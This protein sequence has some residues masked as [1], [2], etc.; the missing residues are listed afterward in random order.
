[1]LSPGAGPNSKQGSCARMALD[2]GWDNDATGFSWIVFV[3]LALPLSISEQGIMSD[4]GS[5]IA[6]RSNP[7]PT[8][9]T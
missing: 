2:A 9:G 3:D 1:M 6:G 7:C 4:V 5:Q 8:A